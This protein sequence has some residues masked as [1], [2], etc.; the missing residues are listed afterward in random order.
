VLGQHSEALLQ[1]RHG[2]D[3]LLVDRHLIGWLIG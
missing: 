2:L 3:V 1:F